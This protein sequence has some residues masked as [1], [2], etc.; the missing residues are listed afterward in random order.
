MPKTQ[1][2]PNTATFL[3]ISLHLHL[4]WAR[5]ESIFPLLESFSHT[6]GQQRQH[7]SKNLCRLII[8]GHVMSK[9]K[10]DKLKRG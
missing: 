6:H 4:Q 10:Q 9:M 8:F 7:S 2:A 1:A 5:K 3:G